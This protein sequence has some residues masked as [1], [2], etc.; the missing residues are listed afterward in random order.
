LTDRPG[1]AGFLFSNQGRADK[2]RGELAE[3]EAEPGPGCQVDRANP[4]NPAEAIDRQPIDPA[5][6]P[7]EFALIFSLPNC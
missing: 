6:P 3:A 7:A 2:R 5:E 1:P 4:P